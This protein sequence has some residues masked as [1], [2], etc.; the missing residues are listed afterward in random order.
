MKAASI[1]LR[2]ADFLKGHPPFEFF[3]HAELVALA[4]DGRVKFHE[5]GEIIFATGRERERFIYVVKQGRVRLVDD[6][7][8]TSG[9]EPLLFDLRGPG[10]LLGLNGVLN[11]APYMNTAIAETDVLLYGLPRRGFLE[12]TERS[13]RARRYL[14]AY[15]SL[16]GAPERVP[17][18]RKTLV[19]SITPTTL[20][21]GGL[22]EVKEPHEVAAEALLTVGTETPA[23]EA[24]RMLQPKRARCIIVVDEAGR[25]VGKLS[26]SDVRNRFIEG[27][28]LANE[29]AGTMMTT[30]LALARQSDDTG[31]L[32]VRMARSGKRYLVVTED[33]TANTKAVGLVAERNIF[34]QYGRFPTLLAEAMGEAPTVP[35]LAALRDRMESLILEYLEDRAHV[36]WLMEMT[37]VLNRAIAARLEYLARLEMA[38]EGWRAPNVVHAWLMMGSGGRDELLIRSAVYHA[39]VYE[40]PPPAEAASTKQYFQE[41]GSI[42]S[43]GVVHCGFHNNETGILASNPEWCLP[44]SAMHARY[45]RMIAEPLASNVY[46]YRDA[47]DFRPVVHLHPLAA[48]LRE[49]INAELKL[50]PEFLRHMAK[51]SLLNQP[52]RTI[53]QQYVINEQGEQKDELAIKH[54][55]LLPLVDAARV[56]ALAAGEVSS[57]ATYLRFRAAA[58]QLEGVSRGQAELF[59]EAAEAFL[60]LAYARARQGLRSG[61][62]GAVIRPADV[63]AETR[64]LLKTA[65]RTILSTLEQLAARYQ[66]TMRA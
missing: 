21:R 31:R 44:R 18:Q 60:V 56:L 45:T 64:P 2:I 29:T 10:E 20:R 12:L 3:D 59:R 49:H 27:R 48:G 11:D 7:T 14:F 13:N 37:G 50:H 33:G 43:N 35:A 58:A 38:A 24:A 26:D 40:D 66:L 4:G 34:L 22:L 25:P 57:T 36:P 65:F 28:V 42:V 47:F 9:G 39:L 17:A 6:T 30:D 32:L 23:L 52:P 1:A 51:D 53:F 61:T 15:F 63:D 8:V 62:S 46:A 41:L 55:A 54:H 16:N 19:D 5:G